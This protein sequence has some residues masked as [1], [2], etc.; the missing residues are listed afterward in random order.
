MSSVKRSV[1]APQALMDQA[2]ARAEALGYT[3]FSHYVQALMRADVLRRTQH[4]R[5]E[6]AL[7]DAPLSSPP[8][9]TKTKPVNYGKGGASPTASQAVKTLLSDIN[10]H[11]SDEP[12]SK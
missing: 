10:P 4:V 5:E 1:S 12:S 8:A 11:S 6:V 9:K 7:R 3:S 2:N